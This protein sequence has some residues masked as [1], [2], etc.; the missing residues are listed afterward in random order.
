MANVPLG[1]TIAGSETT[2]G[3]GL[4][5]DLK[6]FEEFGV[7]GM[8]VIT[9]IVTMNTQTWE[10]EVSMVAMDAINK[11]FDTVFSGEKISAVKTG[12]IPSVDLIQL[13]RD[14]IIDSGIENIVIDPVMVCKGD[15]SEI[16][17]ESS[18]ALRDILV[19]IATVATPNLLEAGVLSGLGVLE[20]IDDIKKAAKIIYESGAKNVVVKGGGSLAG[21]EAIDIVY[22]GKDYEVLSSPKV[23]TQYNSG[24]GCS[25]S[26]AIASCLAKGMPVRTAVAKAKLYVRDAIE[27]GFS[28]NEHAGSVLHSASRVIEGNSLA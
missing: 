20:S 7:H 4:Q 22:D 25:F 26:A 21:D 11:Q 14:R 27:H 19:P 10:H 18:S 8:V 13:S 3:A 15:I 16:N 12:M 28:F 24:A 2:G 23:S 17:I 9:C 6:T 1:L 5:A